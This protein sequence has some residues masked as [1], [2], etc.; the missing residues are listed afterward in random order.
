MHLKNY[1]PG[2]SEEELSSTKIYY[3]AHQHNLKLN[4]HKSECYSKFLNK[5]K[6]P[7]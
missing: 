3:F 5:L 1:K 6:Q 4:S 7:Q 2:Q